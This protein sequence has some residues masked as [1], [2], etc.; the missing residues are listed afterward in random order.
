MK[1]DPPQHDQGGLET[2]D[3]PAAPAAASVIFGDRLELARA[4]AE[5]LAGSG[6]IRGLIGPREAPRLWERHVL[7][8][9]VITDLIA[10]DSTVVDVGSGAGLPGLV[11]AIRRPDL[12]VTLVEPLLRRVRWLD[13]VVEELELS[14]V[15]VVRGRAEALWDEIAP[16]DVVTSRAVSALENLAVWSVPL[17]RPGGWWLPMKGSSVA[18][19]IAQSR[20]LLASIGVTDIDVIE[21]GAEVLTEPTTVAR[22]AV[23]TPKRLSKSGAKGAAQGGKKSAKK[24]RGRTGR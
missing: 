12:S 6:V 15:T 17:V 7:N 21:C 18:E 16:A 9:A 19:E 8:C 3:V 14:N 24:R 22:L 2:A 13:D 4:Y 11:I 20:D 5:L 23:G 1:H 10:R